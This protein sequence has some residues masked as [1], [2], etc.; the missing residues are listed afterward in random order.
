[1]VTLSAQVHCNRALSQHI[2]AFSILEFTHGRGIVCL[3]LTQTIPDYPKRVSKA[4]Q[5]QDTGTHVQTTDS[6]ARDFGPSG[7]GV[8]LE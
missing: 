8:L 1:M 6:M 5:L 3:Y 7:A 2:H 4:T